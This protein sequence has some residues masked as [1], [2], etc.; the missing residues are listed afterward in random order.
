MI[1]S[2]KKKGRKKKERIGS[3]YR[4][5]EWKVLKKEKKKERKKEKAE[6]IISLGDIE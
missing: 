3:R 2:E 5:K 1:K 6:A 4:L